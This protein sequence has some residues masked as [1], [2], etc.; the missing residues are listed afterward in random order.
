MFVKMKFLDYQVNIIDKTADEIGNEPTDELVKLAWV[1]PE[2]LS[3]YKLSPPTV[4]LFKKMK[5]IQ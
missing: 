3:K 2:D 5:I 1:A 4:K